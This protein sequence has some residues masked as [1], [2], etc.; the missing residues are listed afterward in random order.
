MDLKITPESTPTRYVP[1]SSEPKSTLGDIEG[2]FPVRSEF[3]GEGEVLD[4]S[5][6]EYPPDRLLLN[7]VMTFTDT[8]VRLDVL[9]TDVSA[10][11]KT[12]WE[13]FRQ[14][15]AATMEYVA[16]V[17]G[18][19]ANLSLYEPHTWFRFVPPGQMRYRHGAA[20][21]WPEGENVEDFIAAATE[22]RY[23]EEEEDDPDS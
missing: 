12:V 2:Y 9:N 13:A 16:T 18:E 23:E 10:E 1:E 14:L 6:P 7:V 4:I 15:I 3:R 11:G 19:K 8:Q 17:E 21:F 5:A 20:D 22:G